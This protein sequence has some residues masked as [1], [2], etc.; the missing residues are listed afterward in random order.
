MLEDWTRLAALKG[1]NDDEDEIEEEELD[2]EDDEDLEDLEDYDED[3]DWDE[4][5]YEDEDDDEDTE[6]DER[7]L[8]PVRP[9]RHLTSPPHRLCPGEAGSLFFGDCTPAGVL[10]HDGARVALRVG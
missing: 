4:D 2:D 5:E 10:E 1:G 7:G 3:E 6:E 9:S 8:G